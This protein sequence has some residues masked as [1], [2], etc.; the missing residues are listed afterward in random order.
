MEKTLGIELSGEITLDLFAAAVKEFNKLLDELTQEV[1]GTEGFEWELEE[2]QKGSAFIQVRALSEDIALVDRTIRAFDEIAEA[3]ARGEVIGFSPNV[4]KHA[5]A[6]TGLINGQIRAISFLTDFNTYTISEHRDQKSVERQTKSN[7]AWGTVK[8][9]VATI[10]GRQ[11][12]QITVYDSLF[13]KA[14]ICFLPE[15]FLSEAG[16]WWHKE[17]AVTGRVYRDVETGRP[18]RVRDVID[19][20]VLDSQGIEAFEAV[21]GILPHEPND[22]LPEATIRRLRDGV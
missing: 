21:R 10:N 17:V 7:I 12:L 13:D 2:Q 15:K 1:A 20:E 4:A 9:Y 18:I 14:I 11:K 22:E 8:G 3:L 16:E 6:L 5:Y 19:V